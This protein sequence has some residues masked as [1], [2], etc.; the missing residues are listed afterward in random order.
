MNVKT[1]DAVKKIIEDGNLSISAVARGCGISPAAVS[2]YLRGEY[3]GRNDKVE[4]S[5]TAFVRRHREKQAAKVDLDYVDTS[6]ARKIHEIADMV[7]TDCEV[8]VIV[9]DAGVGKTF[10][11]R[12]YAKQNPDVVFVEVDFGYSA[13]WLFKELCREV[14]IEHRSQ[15]SEMA[16][17]IVK[18]LQG[19]G[20]MIV[21]DE[22]E[23]LPHKAL[24]L[25]RRVHDKA[26]V[27]MLLV[28]MP[29]LIYNLRGSRG[30]YAQL[31]SR[32]GVYAR[33]E[34]LSAADTKAVVTS[35]INPANGLYRDFHRA[36]GGNTRTLAKL[37]RRCMRASRIN[38][39][40][41]NSEL[42]AATAE[43]L[44]F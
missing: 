34:K 3:K 28:G 6:I 7:H 18:R 16:A 30:Q 43:T 41:I 31:Y 37:L 1:R 44:L 13:L 26:G 42:V 35:A 14:G 12:E 10:A 9:G 40:E 4:T 36:A 17:G 19:S 38:D 29:R 32:V 33:L 39:A 2:T 15:L 23:Y 8:G 11:L 20:R 5:L 27:G 24:E 25:L 21:V 22:A